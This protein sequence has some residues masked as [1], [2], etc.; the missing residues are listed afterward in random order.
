M[1][2]AFKTSEGADL[3]NKFVLLDFIKADG[4]NPATAGMEFPAEYYVTAHFA[5]PARSQVKGLRLEAVAPSFYKHFFMKNSE[6]ARRLTRVPTAIEDVAVDSE[7]VKT[8]Y[9]NLQGI[10]VK[11]PAA[12]D[13]VVAR[14]Q[15]ANGQFTSKV[16][17]K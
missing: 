1:I 15:H 17:R 2:E 14:Y 3:R 8:V 10:E 4:F 13:I 12:G 5:V 6:R 11:E 7:V 16:I 9:Y